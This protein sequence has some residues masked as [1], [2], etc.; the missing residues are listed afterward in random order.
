[1]RLVVRRAVQSGLVLVSCA[2]LAAAQVLPPRVKQ[3]R[4]AA[5]VNARTAGGKD[6]LQKHLTRTGQAMIPVLNGCLPDE[7]EDIPTPFSLFLRLSQQG[8]VVEVVTDLDVQLGECMTKG[9]QELQL[10][11]PPGD[12]YWIQLNLAASL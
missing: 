1:M 4:D 3:A 7:D 8:R 5:R 12:G 9:S 10:P 6:W 2:A 11:A